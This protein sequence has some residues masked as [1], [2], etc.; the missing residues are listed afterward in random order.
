MARLRIQRVEIERERRI[1]NS[2]THQLGPDQVYRR[3]CELQIAGE[4]AGECVTQI[5]SGLRFFA[6]Q[7]KRGSNVGCETRGPGNAFAFEVVTFAVI[8]QSKVTV[9]SI[10]PP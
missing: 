6:C 7:Q 5:F 10:G 3:S 1:D 2:D 9:P 8:G 4:H